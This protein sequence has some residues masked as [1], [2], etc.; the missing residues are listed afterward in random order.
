MKGHFSFFNILLL[1]I[2]PLSAQSQENDVPLYVKKHECEFRNGSF[3]H[4]L[5]R[6]YCQCIKRNEYESITRYRINSKYVRF[7]KKNYF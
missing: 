5:C 6:L 2:L 7:L 4:Q 3:Y 1:F